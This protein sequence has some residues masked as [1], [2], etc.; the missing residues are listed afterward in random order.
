M[1][2]A[3]NIATT[4]EI[5]ENISIYESVIYDLSTLFTKIGI[6]DNPIKIFEHFEYLINNGFLSPNPLNENVPEYL[7]EIE[8]NGYLTMDTCGSLIFTNYGVCRNTTDFLS[9]IYQTLQY[10]SSQLFSYNTNLEIDLYLPS[11]PI[12][13]QELTSYIIEA[14][15]RLD[16]SIPLTQIV[17]KNFGDV[18]VVVAYNY[19]YKQPHHTTNIVKDKKQKRIHIIDTRYHR[20]GEKRKDN[21]IL[22]Q[23]NKASH[24]HIISDQLHFKT[25]Y[26]N[27]YQHGLK[28]FK[29]YPTN[30]KEDEDEAKLYEQTCREYHALYNEFH[31]AHIHLYEKANDNFITLAKKIS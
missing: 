4:E 19:S 22:F 6:S 20:F 29:K 1:K 24:I 23:S 18:K 28:L 27:H 7:I 10:D 16:F 31:K 17:E 12:D 11:R 30:V 21:S 9:H 3:R 8:N 2:H 15:K 14:T 5:A 13:E 26:T 25:Y